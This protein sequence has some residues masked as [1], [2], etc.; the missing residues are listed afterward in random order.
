MSYLGVLE[1]FDRTDVAAVG[2]KA[3]NVGEALRS[4]F[5]VP[6]GSVIISIGIAGS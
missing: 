6:H 4:G 1:D 2:G 3:V 5:P